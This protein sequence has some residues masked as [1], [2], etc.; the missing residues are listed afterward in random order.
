[1]WDSV[2]RK[3]GLVLIMHSQYLVWSCYTYILT[4]TCK[5]ALAWAQ[6]L[7]VSETN[8]FDRTGTVFG[9]HQIQEGGGPKTNKKDC[10][11]EKKALKKEN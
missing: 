4:S 9:G 2:F 8:H 10:I 7:V 11:E 1:M 5:V 3:P 6:L